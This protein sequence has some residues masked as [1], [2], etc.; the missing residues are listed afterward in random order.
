MNFGVFWRKRPLTSGGHNYWHMV[1]E[2]TR[3]KMRSVRQS[4]T[5]PEIAVRE[6]LTSLGLPFAVRVDGKPS[7]ADLW[8]IKSDIPVFVHGCFWHRHEGCKKATTPKRNREL[9]LTKFQNNQARD[10]RVLNHLNALGYH[11]VTIWQCETVPQC[12][13][14]ELLAARIEESQK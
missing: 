4:G 14:I 10:A 1:D 9:W 8:L 5:T 13:L 3:R 12:R 7:S 6:A 11:P 2:A